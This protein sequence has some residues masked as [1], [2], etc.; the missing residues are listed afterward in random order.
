MEKSKWKM[1]RESMINIEDGFLIVIGD[2]E[3]RAYKISECAMPGDIK[4]GAWDEGVTGVYQ[5]RKTGKFRAQIKLDRYRLFSFT[6]L[7]ML[8]DA[9]I[10][11]CLLRAH[12]DK[13]IGR[14]F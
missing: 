4:I 7:V 13:Y 11:S 10:V 3:N 1:V 5:D 14:L 6:P 9:K 12:I 8:V 2:G